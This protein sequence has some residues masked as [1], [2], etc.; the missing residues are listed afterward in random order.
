MKVLIGLWV[1]SLFLHAYSYEELMNEYEAK[2]FERVCSEGSSFLM[3]NEKNENILTIIGDACARVD[4]INP[5]GNV[6][7]NLI[8]TPETRENASYFS[9]LILQKKLIYQFMCDGINLKDLRLPRTDHVLSRV[10]EE[11]TKGNYTRVDHKIQISTPNMD[12]LLWLSNDSLK[13]V[14]IEEIKNE[15]LINR[16]WYL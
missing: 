13:K 3:K 8:K 12:Y 1:M 11:L 4:F 6:I 16:H 10:F 5:L 2:N 14:F 15:K 9:T 7:K